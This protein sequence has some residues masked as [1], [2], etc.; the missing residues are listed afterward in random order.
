MLYRR[1]AWACSGSYARLPDERRSW[2]SMDA[3]M[4]TPTVF[5][6]K[7]DLAW[8]RWVFQTRQVNVGHTTLS[9]AFVNII[10]ERFNRQYSIFYEVC[11]Y[12]VLPT[13]PTYFSRSTN[14]YCRIVPLVFWMM[15]QQRR[16]KTDPWFD[17]IVLSLPLVFSSFLGQPTRHEIVFLFCGNPIAFWSPR[18]YKFGDWSRYFVS[19]F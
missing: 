5:S 4:A 12:F 18:S 15:N 17:M 2:S 14:V 3:T 16:L 19:L 9:Q 1:P 6:W 10:S 8:P 11:T 13:Y 7:L